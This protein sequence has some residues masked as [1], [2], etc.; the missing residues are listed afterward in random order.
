MSDISDARAFTYQK[1]GHHFY[2]LT[3]PTGNKTFVFD[4]STSLWHER[5][6][7]VPSTTINTVTWATQTSAIADFSTNDV[8]WNGT[9]FCAIGRTD[10][11][12]STDKCY[13]SPDGITWTARTLPSSQTWWAIEWNGT[14][15]CAIA[16]G[17]F[18]SNVAATSTDGITWTA[19]T[20]SA[21][22]NYYDIAWNGTVFCAVAT[23]TSSCVTSPDGITWTNR[24]LPTY[25]QWYR[26]AWNGTVFCVVTIAESVACA[27]SPDGITWSSASSAGRSGASARSSGPSSRAQA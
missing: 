20:L 24:S 13:T 15:F 11:G 25:T 18:I 3:F 4:A 16:G 17:Q 10:A 23:A 2:V 9:V 12:A 19:R 21:S 26:I 7:T 5:N 8:V 6:A 14:V 1:D 27:T 22:L